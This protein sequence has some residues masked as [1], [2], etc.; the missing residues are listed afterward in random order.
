MVQEQTGGLRL[1]DCCLLPS[2]PCCPAAALSAMILRL[3]VPSLLLDCCLFEAAAGALLL[4]SLAASA[5][6]C[7]LQAA[8]LQALAIFQVDPASGL[9]TSSNAVVRVLSGTPEDECLPTLMPAQ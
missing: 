5:V 4:T 6:A 3:G 2:M 1:E 7:A 9:I 8:E